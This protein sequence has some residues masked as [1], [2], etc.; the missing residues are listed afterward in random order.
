MKSKVLEENKMYNINLDEKE[1]KD[2]LTAQNTK[3]VL[4]K[5]NTNIDDKRENIELYTKLYY[6]MGGTSEGI[7]RDNLA[8]AIAL[9]VNFCNNPDEVMKSSSIPSSNYNNFIEIADSIIK[10]LSRSKDNMLSPE[11]F[12]NVMTAE[13]EVNQGF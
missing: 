10:T 8:K 2:L 5:S 12:I 4:F 13:D 11:D 7:S 3:E 6:L 9:S 1:F